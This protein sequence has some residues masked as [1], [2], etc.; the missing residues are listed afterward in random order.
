MQTISKV[1]PVAIMEQIL[2]CCLRRAGVTSGMTSA[3]LVAVGL[4]LRSRRAMPL[5]RLVSR[6]FFQRTAHQ[7]LA[8]SS[9]LCC[10][11]KKTTVM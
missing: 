11:R 4:G 9:R 7:P 6:F 10:P 1:T 5:L 8:T 3:P 2:R